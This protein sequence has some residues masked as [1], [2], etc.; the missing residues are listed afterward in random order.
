M[1]SIPPSSFPLTLNNGTASLPSVGLGTFQ[2]TFQGEDG[3]EGVSDVVYV[4]IKSGYR[5]IDTAFA[6]GSESEVGKGIKRALEDGVITTRAD[7]WVTTKLCA[8]P[9]LSACSRASISLR[10]WVY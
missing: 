8:P 3:N 9:R 10:V 5:H 7:I 4:A 6:Y 2:G 1:A